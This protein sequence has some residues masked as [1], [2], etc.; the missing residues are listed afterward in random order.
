MS[1]TKKH[2][3]ALVALLAML[4]TSAAAQAPEESVEA[5]AEPA[6]EIAEE[7]ASPAA[8]TPAEVPPPP[9][10]TC[11][12]RAREVA[13]D[14]GVRVRSGDEWGAGFVYGSPRTVVTSFGLLS[15]GRPVTVV[16]RDGTHLE[17]RVVASDESYDLA[18]LET[19]APVPGAT[20][21]QP[22]PE[23]SAMLGM[24]VVAIGHPHPGAARALGPRGQGLL[25]WSVSQGTIGAVNENGIQADL[26]LSEGFAGAP[27]LDCEGRALGM[28][29]G[30]GLLGP[31]LGLAARIGHADELIEH[32]APS[33]EFH[34][35]L[36]LRFGI[37]GVILIDQE[38]RVAGGGY[39][40]LGAT[41][42]D[43]L[44]WMNRV[45]LLF[46]GSTPL[47]PS[48][49]SVDR[50]LVRVESLL[51]WRF[52]VDVGGFT[53]FYIV[54]AIGLTVTHTSETRRSVAVAPVAGCTPSATDAC[55]AAQITDANVEGWEVHPA[56]GLT[57]LFGNLAIGYTLEIRVDEPVTTFHAVNLGF[58][59]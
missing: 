19:S 40:T 37:G 17:A 14:A 49:L 15:L 43:R 23:T 7:P 26:S 22:A 8:S 29:A 56:A 12:A 27:L 16:A 21:L 11:A 36:R 50:T 25:R 9:V 38:G 30:A 10:A 41:L 52:F 39:V 48:E 55:L 2:A 45:G 34:G 31:G 51:G 18:I 24:P 44:S 4:T 35:N 1:S 58:L 32:A 33:G 28:I 5:P 54:P 57:F 47:G 46:G 3:A 20:P 59:F 6:P 53:T 42:F 13:V